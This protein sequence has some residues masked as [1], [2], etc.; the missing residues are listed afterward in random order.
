MKKNTDYI[1]LILM[2]LTLIL[3]IVIIKNENVIKKIKHKLDIDKDTTK[4]EIIYEEDIDSNLYLM[5]Y[6][7]DSISYI[8]YV[9]KHNI[10][11]TDSMVLTFNPYNAKDT[12]AIIYN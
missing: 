10:N 11:V 12:L 2:T 5:K 1:I 8:I 7:E 9:E 6:D 4:V 3:L